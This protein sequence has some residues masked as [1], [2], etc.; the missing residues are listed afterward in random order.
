MKLGGKCR[1]MSKFISL[2]LWPNAL[3]VIPE[4]ISQCPQEY[5]VYTFDVHRPDTY[6]HLTIQ[7]VHGSSTV[8]VPRVKY[9]TSHQF[10]NINST[11]RWKF[12]HLGGSVERLTSFGALGACDSQSKCPESKMYII[13]YYPSP[14]LPWLSE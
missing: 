13:M 10:I 6:L 8:Y 1:R 11:L 14:D 7:V 12:E 3:I 4:H 9:S 5:S 2:V